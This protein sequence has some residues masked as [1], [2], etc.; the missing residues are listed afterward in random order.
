[1][2]RLLRALALFLVMVV[3]SPGP[4]TA[5]SRLFDGANLLGRIAPENPFRSIHL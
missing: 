1:M 4:G 2:H 3:L 5:Q